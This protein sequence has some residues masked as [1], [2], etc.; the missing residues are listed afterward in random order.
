MR[1]QAATRP[2]GSSAKAPRAAAVSCTSSAWSAPEARATY[3]N[4]SMGCIQAG[5]LEA[6][7]PDHEV[8]HHQEQHGG[9]LAA[10]APL[11]SAAASPGSSFRPAGSMATV[12][13]P[14]GANPPSRAGANPG[15]SND[16]NVSPTPGTDAKLIPYPHPPPRTP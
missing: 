7:L 14:Q 16:H 2:D 6:G 10:E 9:D 3:R 13:N 12:N 5:R 15:P 8:E 11:P 4:R 1:R